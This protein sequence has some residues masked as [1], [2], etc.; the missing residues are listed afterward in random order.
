MSAPEGAWMKSGA[1]EWIV[2]V[3]V[4]QCGLLRNGYLHLWRRTQQGSPQLVT[5]NTVLV[6][7]CLV[8]P[9]PIR[10]LHAFNRPPSP[11]GWLL[12]STRHLARPLSA[13][14]SSTQQHRQAPYALAAIRST[15]TCWPQSRPSCWPGIRSAGGGCCSGRGRSMPH[16]SARPVWLPR[17]RGPMPKPQEV[18]ALVLGPVS[19]GPVAGMPSRCCRLAP[20]RWS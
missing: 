18:I 14:T 1:D 3:T 20:V 4:K 19:T 2:G 16:W 9:Q 12:L 15:A 7:V 11:Q 13:V 8:E 5:M 6:T 10:K 17:E